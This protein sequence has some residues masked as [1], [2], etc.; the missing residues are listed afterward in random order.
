MK[1]GLFAIGLSIVVAGVAACGAKGAEGPS[2]P[3]PPTPPAPA[4]LSMAGLTP[5]IQPDQFLLGDW[6]SADGKEHEHWLVAAGALYGVRF[7]ATGGFTCTMIDDTGEA[8]AL[9]RWT[10]ADGKSAGPLPATD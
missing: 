5:G 3:V 9:Q 8:R 2:K 1:R 6:V 7:T 10:Y 4:P